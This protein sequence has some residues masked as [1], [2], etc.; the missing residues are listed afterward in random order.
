[1]TSVTLQH[2]R[3]DSACST[4]RTAFRSCDKRHADNN[5]GRKS[6]YKL[7]SKLTGSSRKIAINNYINNGSYVHYLSEP[8][9]S[10]TFYTPAVDCIMKL[11]TSKLTGYVM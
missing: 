11:A 6:S 7:S 2:G 3:T 10:V 9:E 8:S 4:L 5:K 1:M